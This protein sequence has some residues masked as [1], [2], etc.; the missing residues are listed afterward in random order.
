MDRLGS[1]NAFVRGAE[2][3]SFTV[4]GRP[5]T[6]PLVRSRLTAGGNRIRTIGPA[7]RDGRFDA[8]DLVFPRSGS[9]RPQSSGRP[10]TRPRYRTVAPGTQVGTA[11][12]ARGRFPYATAGR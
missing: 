11:T 3:R 2:A 8:R 7:V 5:L 6:H 9:D 10:R 12:R 4:A 1:L